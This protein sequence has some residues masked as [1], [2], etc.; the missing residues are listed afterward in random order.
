[1][2][3]FVVLKSFVSSYW[4]AKKVPPLL[5]LQ[6]AQLFSQN[7]ATGANPDLP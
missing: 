2:F 6:G 5:A 4:P 7:A 1:M 3:W